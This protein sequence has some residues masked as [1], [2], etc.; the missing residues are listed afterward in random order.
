MNYK[1]HHLE[2]PCHTTGLVLSEANPAIPDD[3][4]VCGDYAIVGSATVPDDRVCADE[5]CDDKAA[6]VGSATIP[7]D[8][9]CA[10][11][12]YDDATT[13]SISGD[14]VCADEACDNKATVSISTDGI[15][16]EDV[17]VPARVIN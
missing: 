15:T 13:I 11:G 12:E 2:K 16:S 9:V 17:S 4:E 6:V 1:R 5:T 14:G 10:E 3:G 8:G 7:E